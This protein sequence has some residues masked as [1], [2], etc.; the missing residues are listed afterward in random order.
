MPT[1]EIK[2]GQTAAP[3]STG[4]SAFGSVA[5]GQNEGKGLQAAGE[6]LYGFGMEKV[7]EARR[8]E[9]DLYVST[10]FIEAQK[11]A[12][13]IQ[14]QLRQE[15][16]EDP[17][18]YSDAVMENLRTSFDP[19]I[20][21][22]PSTEAR[23]QLQSQFTGVYSNALNSSHKYEREQFVGNAQRSLNE[24]VNTTDS[25]LAEGQ[26]SF[27]AAI[28]Q[29]RGLIDAADGVLFTSEA[30]TE[31]ADGVIKRLAETHAIA[32]GKSSVEEVENFL[33]N[34]LPDDM[35]SAE[36]TQSILNKARS[37]YAKEN[38]VT[39]MAGREARVAKST[40][41]NAHLVDGDVAA[42]EKELERGVAE[43][44]LEKG[45]GTYMNLYNTIQNH[46][47]ALFKSDVISREIAPVL[48]GDA[49]LDQSNPDH[50]KHWDSTFY[51][52]YPQSF[53]TVKDDETKEKML[54]EMVSAGRVPSREMSGLSSAL[55][56]NNGKVVAT[57]AE[58]VNA[59][60]D[61]GDGILALSIDGKV[62][63][64]A[65]V[66]RAALDG[67]KMNGEQAVEAVRRVQIS[68]QSDGTGLSV[69]KDFSNW[70]SS[71]EGKEA[72]KNIMNSYV[73]GVDKIPV[74]FRDDLSISASLLYSQ[75]ASDQ[76]EIISKAEAVEITAK[77]LTERVW[78]KVSLFGRDSF[79]R[80]P[81]TKT[82]EG[83]S[84][85]FER[86]DFT[87]RQLEEAILDISYNQNKHLGTQ[88]ASRKI[89][90]ITETAFIIPEETDGSVS[91]QVGYFDESG[92]R[93][94]LEVFVEAGEDP[95]TG[96]P[97]GG[98][99]EPI[100]IKVDRKNE[101]SVMFENSFQ[102]LGALSKS[103]EERGLGFIDIQD[104][105]APAL[106][107]GVSPS[108]MT[109]RSK[110]E[111]RL[112]M[113]P[114]ARDNKSD[115]GPSVGKVWDAKKAIVDK[116]NKAVDLLNE[117]D[118]IFDNRLDA[119]MP[120]GAEASEKSRVMR[121]G[122]GGGAF[123]ELAALQNAPTKMEEYMS[124][125]REYEELIKEANSIMDTISPEDVINSQETPV[126][127]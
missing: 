23:R 58:T 64:K 53:L 48:S 94:P 55:L 30:R 41:V 40:V 68:K 63:N 97:T 118:S 110:Q 43:G 96:M 77:N 72:V 104:R 14:D 29:S 21:G 25:L 61:T 69:S 5:F 37:N 4:R 81:P 1:V 92:V 88:E 67:A 79:M 106:D 103:L 101:P 10:K 84:I 78:G 34:D 83:Q 42:A 90:R 121:A 36:E 26:I 122:F 89:A 46:K 107:R 105:V 102:R 109:K 59:L 100:T 32:M 74:G 52:K 76:E 35:F 86:D 87:S 38:R 39:E 20:E 85:G 114:R 120:V 24:G 2:R 51:Q 73:K 50:V 54:N 117:A 45:D 93:H 113:N 71:K 12:L 91:Y 115:K 33:Y 27:E 9:D 65:R 70:Y 17:K 49:R 112:V 62:A 95:E 99:S 31:K 66:Y 18:G 22:A 124:T 116:Y 123:T 125:R 126:E 127:E 60:L 57:A 11:Q 80:L 119:N 82:K 16:S 111:M 6:A 47:V 28:E 15:Y 3:R 108:A 98:Q 7:E 75:N 19:I 44:V 13:D 56:S 8:A